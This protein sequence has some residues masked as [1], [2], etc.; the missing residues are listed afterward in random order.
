MLFHRLFFGKDSL[1]GVTRV[2]LCICELCNFALALVKI[3][4]QKYA[5]LM[6]EGDRRCC[7]T[8]V[9]MVQQQGSSDG[10][11]DAN[12]ERCQQYICI[13]VCIS[14]KP[15]KSH[16][17]LYLAA[18]SRIYTWGFPL[19]Q[20]RHCEVRGSHGPNEA[21]IQGGNSPT[22]PV[23]RLMVMPISQPTV[24]IHSRSLTNFP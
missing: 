20:T 21:F 19:G 7:C 16:G 10:L 14:N 22:L 13:S 5:F 4:A 2:F 23:E 18:A 15:T 17:N 12:V 6:F 1:K 9:L 8:D 24:W 11:Q 3:M